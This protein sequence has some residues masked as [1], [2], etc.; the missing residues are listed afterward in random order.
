[1][2]AYPA[3]QKVVA[4]EQPFDKLPPHAVLL[5][6]VILEEERKTTTTTTTKKKKKKKR[7]TKGMK[8]MTKGM[9]A[10]GESS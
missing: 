5:P 6:F 7:M 1:M 8:R 3:R 2:L 4:H 9:N 10:W